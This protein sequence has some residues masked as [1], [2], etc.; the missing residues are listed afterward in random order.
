MIFLLTLLFVTRKDWKVLLTIVP[1][2]FLIPLALQM[3][4]D[5]VIT[6]QTNDL[7]C[8]ETGA[9]NATF[10]GTCT[11]V[12]GTT[13]YNLDP[14]LMVSFNL[15]VFLGV[16]MVIAYSVSQALELR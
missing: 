7:G 10:T 1:I 5:K 16:I 3:D 8:T 4:S 9:L 2:V 15:L 6:Y 13:T 12:N 14:S 11:Y